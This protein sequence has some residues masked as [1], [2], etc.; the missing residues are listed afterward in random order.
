MYDKLIFEISK[1]GRKGYSLPKSAIKEYPFLDEEY[2]RQ[3][4][5]ELRK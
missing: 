2:L 5:P 4:E 3:T 1:Q